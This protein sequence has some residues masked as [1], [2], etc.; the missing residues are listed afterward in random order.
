MA[1]ARS[2]PQ[3]N[4]IELN[5]ASAL[6]TYSSEARDIAREFAYELDWAAQELEAV[7]VRN[8]EGN[9]W[10]MGLDVRWRARRVANRARRAAELARGSGT[11]MVKL[12]QDF[13]IQ[14]A[15]ALEQNEKARKPSF[16]FDN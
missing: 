2:I 5:S 7:L 9:P 12:W 6:K 11:E 16:D 1:K 3:L 15:P 10:L 14:F 13:M 8:G 4:T